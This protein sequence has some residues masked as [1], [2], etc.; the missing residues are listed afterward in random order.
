MCQKIGQK[1]CACILCV[2]HN[3]RNFVIFPECGGKN[4]HFVHE[5]ADVGKT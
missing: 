4:F 1:A 2:L 5:T 3:V